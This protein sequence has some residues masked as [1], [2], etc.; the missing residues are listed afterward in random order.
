[1]AGMIAW[2]FAAALLGAL[3]TAALAAA[4]HR[5]WL[6][7]RLEARLAAMQDEFER[8]VKT[9]VLAAG[10]ELLPALREQVALGFQD[11]LR[12][13]KAAG[14]AEGTAKVVTGSADLLVDGLGNLFGLKKK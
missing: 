1:M 2:L 3:A 4:V 7:P 13:S 8:R 12:S 11:A 5:L 14:L 10:Q 6:A 9:G